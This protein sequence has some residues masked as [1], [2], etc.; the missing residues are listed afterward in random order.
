[1]L[2]I[3]G[4]KIRVADSSEPSKL[5]VQMPSSSVWHPYWILG[6]DYHNYI[7]GYSCVDLKLIKSVEKVSHRRVEAT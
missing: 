3:K 7:V 4:I 6:S 5:E 1:M 2:S